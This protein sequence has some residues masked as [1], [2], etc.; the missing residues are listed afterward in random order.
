MVTWKFSFC[1]FLSPTV[2]LVI[3]HPS[4]PRSAD[5]ATTLPGTCFLTRRFMFEMVLNV[6]PIKTDRFEAGPS[7]KNRPGPTFGGD[8]CS[9]QAQEHAAQKDILDALPV[10][11][12]AVHWRQGIPREYLYQGPAPPPLS[13]H[14]A[15]VSAEASSLRRCSTETICRSHET[16]IVTRGWQGHGSA[17]KRMLV[18]RRSGKAEKAAGMENVPLTGDDRRI[19]G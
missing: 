8:G 9:E 1:N 10:A 15:P 3:R 16:G 14:K 13:A 17:G 4:W 18:A 11:A 2:I 5:E 6:N 19:C 12:Q 7:Q